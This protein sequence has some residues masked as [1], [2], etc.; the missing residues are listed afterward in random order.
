MSYPK[1]ESL[2]YP[3]SGN[4]YTWAELPSIPGSNPTDGAGESI[5]DLTHMNNDYA[6][7]HYVVGSLKHWVFNFRAIPIAMFKSLVIF[8]KEGVFNFYP[9]AAVSSTYYQVRWIHDGKIDPPLL[10]GGYVNLEIEL[11]EF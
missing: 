5:K 3:S 4:T 2:D 7:A 1:F 6:V 10:G 8:A 9:D 11:E